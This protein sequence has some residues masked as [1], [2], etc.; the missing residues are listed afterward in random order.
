MDICNNHKIALFRPITAWPFPYSRIKELS[1]SVK[2]VFVFE[3]NYGQMLEDVKIAIDND[4]MIEFYG[5]TNL[6]Y[7]NWRNP[8]SI[9]IKNQT[10]H[11]IS[12]TLLE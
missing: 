5:R 1:K 11:M 4:S 3:L 6:D 8:H 12:Q 10:K 2:K 7:E 9:L